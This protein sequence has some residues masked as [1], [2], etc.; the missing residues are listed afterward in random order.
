MSR[1]RRQQL[2]RSRSW[3]L[4]VRDTVYGWRA[5]WWLG[6]RERFKAWHFPKVERRRP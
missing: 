3:F 2:K 6:G 5:S 4:E 1:H